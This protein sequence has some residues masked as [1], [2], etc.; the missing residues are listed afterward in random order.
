MKKRFI[1]IM[2]VLV[3]SLTVL[4]G[5]G[6]PKTEE[7]PAEPAGQTENAPAEKPE[8]GAEEDKMDATITVLV[9]DWGVPSDEMLE[10]FKAQTGITVNVETAGWDD[11]KQKVSI[12]S[13]GS[14][15]AADVFEVDWSWVG[16]FQAAGWLDPVEFSDEIVKDI[17]SLEYFK[18][19]DAYYSLP[20][21]N[22]YRVALLNTEMAGDEDP[23]TYDDLNALLLKAKEDGKIEYPIQFPLSAE[24]KT[25]TSFMTLAYT[26]NGLFF[27]EDG[28]ANEDSIRDAFE[29]LDYQLE[30]GLIDP[31]ETSR[32]G[33]DT[34]RGISGGEGAFLI[35]PTSFIAR[36]DN[37]EASEVVGQVKSIMLPGKD[38]KAT[39]TLAFTEALGVSSFSEN[40]EA[41]H[42]FIEY[43]ASP[44]AQEKFYDSQGVIPTRYS[45]IE[46]IINDG[47]MENPGTL[48]E[49]AELIENPFPQGVPSYYSQMSA[50]LFN[51]VNEFGQRKL[52]VD[53][54]TTKLVE[55]INS[56]VK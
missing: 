18:V 19:E 23:A 16:E 24:E 32:P 41:A 12:A 48:L 51:I 38:G 21:I 35:G 10:D 39:S 56:F 31:A 14:N 20:F 53:E 5:C 45:V 36:V 43:M 34:F 42:K 44:E 17:K 37:P 26:R 15:A 4:V 13:A 8:D 49:E 40:K 22:D 27:N 33:I 6:G 55:A 9:P 50:E 54:A 46:K 29:V 25:T 47:K 52:T 7:S 2:L 11:I 30:N 1:S 28:T 3:L